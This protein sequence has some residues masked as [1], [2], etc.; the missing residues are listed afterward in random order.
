MIE[1]DCVKKRWIMI[2]TCL[3]IMISLSAVSA[4]ESV[5]NQTFS[6]DNDAI[7]VLGIS[8]NNII[9]TSM[10]DVENESDLLANSLSNDNDVLSEGDGG[11]FSDL[12]T[13][14]NGDTTKTE[15]TLQG[16]YVFDS[17]K[18]DVYKLIEFEYNGYDAYLVAIYDPS[19]V[20]LVQTKYL[21]TYG[22]TLL[23]MAKENGAL[24]AINAGGFEDPNGQG[25]GGRPMGAVIKD[26]KLVWGNGNSVRELAGFTKDN[27]S[28]D[29]FE[30]CSP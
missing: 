5:E 14:I 19:R 12:N 2:S 23:N 7:N 25:N 11:S 17:D 10:E 24:A 29:G 26:G 8:S 20:S 22:Q 28:S 30:L 21:G 16:D 13:L 3:F 18:D 15:I 6:S 9:S 4:G 1:V 27:I